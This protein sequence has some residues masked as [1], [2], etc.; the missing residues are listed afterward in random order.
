MQPIC[1]FMQTK[2]SYRLVCII[3]PVNYGPEVRGKKCQ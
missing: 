2:M 1:W 3:F